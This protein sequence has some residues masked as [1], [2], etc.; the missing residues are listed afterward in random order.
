MHPLTLQ[1]LGELSAATPRHWLVTGA[2]G[3]IGSH[4]CESLLRLGQRVTALDNFDTGK[5]SNLEDVAARV[6]AD[7]WS[8]FRLVEADICDLDACR[9][10]CRDVEYVL[11]QAALGSVRPK[12]AVSSFHSANAFMAPLKPPSA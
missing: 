11:H 6:G 8:G 9:E 5:R 4:L 7:A 1:A 10:A 3:F 12:G 2:A